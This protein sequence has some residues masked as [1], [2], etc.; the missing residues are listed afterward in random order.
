MNGVV[1]EERGLFQRVGAVGDD[2]TGH[3]HARQVLLHAARQTH[4]RGVVHVATVDLRQR[5]AFQRLTRQRRHGRDER[6]GGQGT[7]GVADVV[8]RPRRCAGD[9]AAGANDHDHRRRAWHEVLS[10]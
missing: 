10:G 4:P 1:Q 5:L 3:I 6:V 7:G 2:D 8:L 9:G